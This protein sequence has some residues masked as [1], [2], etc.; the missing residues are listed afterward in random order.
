MLFRSANYCSLAFIRESQIDPFSFFSRSHR[1]RS[2]SFGR[3]DC[4]IFILQF[5]IRLRGKGYR[6]PGS[7]SCLDGTPKA[8]YDA[9]EISTHGDDPLRSQHLQYHVRVMRNS[10]EFRQSWSSDDGVIPAV[11]ARHLEP[12]EHDSVDL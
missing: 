8:L 7:E 5:V 11:E 10:H 12:Q 9:L 4:E 6:G 2:L 3:R 1:G